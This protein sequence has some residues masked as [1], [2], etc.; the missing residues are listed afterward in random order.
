M[1]IILFYARDP[2]AANCILP[3]YHKLKKNKKLKIILCGKDYALNL[4]KKECVKFIDIA[5]KVKVLDKESVKIFLQNHSVDAVVSGVGSTDIT[6]RIIWQAAKDLNI[7]VTTILDQWQNYKMRFSLK[8][9]LYLKVKNLNHNILPDKIC[10]MDEV[11]KKEM[12]QEGFPR[13]IIEVTGH[14]YFEAAIKN[15][16]KISKKNIREFKKGIRIDSKVSI[17]TFVS[18]PIIESYKNHFFCGYNQLTILRNVIECL[19]GLTKSENEKNYCLLVKLHPR[20]DRKIMEDFLEEYQLKVK[21]RII[22]LSGESSALVISCSDLII[23]MSSMFL[24]ESVL[25]KKPVLS[26]QIGLDEKDP[27]ILSRIGCFKTI[28]SR[29]NL[30]KKMN[31]WMTR[32]S[33]NVICFPV[34][35]NSVTNVIK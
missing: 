8:P 14:P 28:V 13:D 19:N 22:V 31:D 27:F 21:F 34:V 23:G 3:I 11:A 2:G 20:N 12:L 32:K 7:R 24:L 18:E 26:V 15:Y 16:K 6:D 30:V 35:K 10:V 25:A 4:Y 5:K 1:K 33:D 29:K 17:I 9:L